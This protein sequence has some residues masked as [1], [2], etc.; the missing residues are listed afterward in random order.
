M[1]LLVEE[2]GETLNKALLE[3][4]NFAPIANSHQI[5]ISYCIG[6]WI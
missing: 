6:H 1:H 2:V 3:I 4:H 5:L